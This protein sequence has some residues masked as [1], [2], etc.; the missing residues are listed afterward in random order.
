MGKVARG[1]GV[2]SERQEE[3]QE[4]AP[5]WVD[6][7]TDWVDRR[8]G[9][10]WAYY[11]GLGLGL[12]SVQIVVLWIEGAFPTDTFF[13]GQVF[14]AGITAYLLALFQYSDNRAA[15]ALS[16]L[17]PALKA[18]EEEYDRLRYEIT[19]LPARPTL[20]ASVVTLLVATVPESLWGTL[21]SYEALVAA[22]AISGALVYS[23]YLLTWCIFG[24]LIYRTIRQMRLI[25]RI[26]TRHTHI[27]LFRMGPL[28]A[29]SGLTALMAVGLTLPPYGFLAINQEILYDPRSVGVIF[30]ITVLGVV[31]FAWPL[32]G[33]HRLL[34]KE[35]EKLLEESSRRLEATI[36]DLHQRVDSAELE[37]MMDLNMAIA[38]LEMEQ[39]A[40]SRIPTW[41]WQPETVRLLATALVLP[42]L[43]LIAQIAL[44]FFTGR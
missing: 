5:S 30:L 36:V 18:T 10:S 8:P 6:R 37:G 11:A 31:T 12:L 7:F 23:I 22:S 29:F 17:R 40:L 19:T 32:L 43:L 38:S 21:S 9:P 44:Q 16:A 27:N 33:I 28:Y 39:Q 1:H 24:A 42:L 13:P 2:D 25:N 41:P 20:L 14:M 34:V 15:A 35:K 3:W 4:Y 26:Y